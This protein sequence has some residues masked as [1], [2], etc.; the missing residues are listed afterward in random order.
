[1]ATIKGTS[2]ADILRGASNPDTILGGAGDDIIYG[3]PGDIKLDGGRSGFDTLD[4]SG[5]T[6]NLRYSEIGGQLSY[7]PSD[8]SKTTVVNFERVIGSGY[9]DYLLGAGGADTL[10]GNGGNDTFEGG[11]GNDVVIGDFRAGWAQTGAAGADVFQF[12]GGDSGNDRILDFQYNVD[13]LFFYGVA[14]PTQ[15]AVSGSD[16]VVSYGSG[17]TVTLVGLGYLSPDSY[18]GLFVYEND[19]LIVPH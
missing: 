3:V 2:R 11:S 8:T 19:G 4:L 10:V 5:A 18:G 14:Q 9:N 1:M 13:H 7:W 12:S 16:L 15:F 6:G 17:S